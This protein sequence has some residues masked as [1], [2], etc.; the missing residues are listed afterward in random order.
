MDELE[1]QYKEAEESG[2]YELAEQLKQQIQEMKVQKEMYKEQMKE[3]KEQMKEVIKSEYT[4]EELEELEEIAEE[5]AE[6]NPGLLIL[7]VENI[8]SVDAKIKF[9]TPP[10]IKGNRTLIPVRAIV[11]AFGAEVQ[12]NAEER[13]VIVLKD[14]KEIVLQLGST[15][16]YI[17]GVEYETDAPAELINNRTLV[18][19]RFL[20]ETFGLKVEWDG[21]TQTIELSD[22]D[23]GETS[24][25]VG[26]SEQ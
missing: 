9:D 3:L 6:N 21:D 11:E 8:I 20:M 10:V 14:D 5:L 24:E 12:W 4:E 26:G 25:D 17:D 1:D 7:P 19:L 13:E 18:P 22:G 15:L 2:N 23:D 16:M